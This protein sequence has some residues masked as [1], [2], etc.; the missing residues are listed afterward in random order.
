[1]K[2]P[3]MLALISIM[4]ILSFIGLLSGCAAPAPAPTPAPAPVPTPETSIPANYSTY[5]E[6]GLFS[7]SYPSNWEIVTSAA[8]ELLPEVKEQLQSVA[9]ELSFEQISMIFYAGMPVEGGYMPNVNII[10]EPFLR[11]F[12][13]DEYAEASTRGIKEVTISYREFS[14][15]KKDIGGREAYILD[16][17]ATFEGM[18]IGHFLMLGLPDG[19]VGWGITCTSL[20]EEYSKY[21]DDFHAILNSFRILK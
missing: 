20:P 1:M 18:G 3:I 2:K 14:R 19:K 21:E 17:E 11:A 8:Q 13:V 12:T 4:T 5:T 15:T 16:C 6:E 7:I 10:V 9:P